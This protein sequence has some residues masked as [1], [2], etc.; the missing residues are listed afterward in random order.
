MVMGLSALV[1]PGQELR[2]EPFDR[3][4]SPFGLAYTISASE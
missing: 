4:L 2:T 1:I 3:L